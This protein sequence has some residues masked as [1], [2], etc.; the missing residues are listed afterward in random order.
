[1]AKHII[2]GWMTV[3]L[4][5]LVCVS[6]GADIIRVGPEGD[7]PTIQEGIQAALA[8]DTVLVA[9]G[10]YYE[11]VDFL[12]KAITVRGD[13]AAATIDGGGGFAVVTM[14]E[15]GILQNFVITN[16]VLGILCFDGTPR[17]SQVTVVYNTL[18]LM[19]LGGGSP[20]IN[21]CIFW[22]NSNDDL[23][24]TDARYSC[25]QEGNPGEGNICIDPL[26]VDAAGGDYRLRSRIGRF[27]QASPGEPGWSEPVWLNELNGIHGYEAG[28]PCLSPDRSTIYFHRFIPALEYGCIVEACRTTPEGP[29][30]S[31]RV[32]TELCTAG[33]G[34]FAP[35]VSEDGLRLYYKEYIV[36]GNRVRMAQ[37]TSVGEVWTPVHAF[38]ELHTDGAIC[39]Q[40]A[41][42][43]DEL[44]IVWHSG[45]QTR[46]GWGS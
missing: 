42:T 32:L 38:Y 26:F 44:T 17:V 20:Q 40:P 7:Y 25:V 2:A 45:K 22:H 19:A 28:S 36:E 21:S 39:S 35:W 33:Y 16:G 9:P 15:E 6:A 4:V 27:N 41:L 5:S 12:G 8:S 46:F 1:M 34:V 29:F 13:G 30:T 24:G 23:D 18:G 43:A 11:E 10:V 31:E 3:L 14:S 37:R